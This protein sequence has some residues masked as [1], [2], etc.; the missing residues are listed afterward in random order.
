MNI[1]RGGGRKTE[2]E[3]VEG[4]F[5]FIEVLRIWSLYGVLADLEAKSLSDNDGRVSLLVGTP[6]RPL[7]LIFSTITTK[8]QIR[9]SIIEG[10]DRLWSPNQAILW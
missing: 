5:F 2:R 10:I 6:T 7:A 3:T 1:E 8:F 4:V 9:I